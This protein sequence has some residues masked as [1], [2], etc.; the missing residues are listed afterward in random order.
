MQTQQAKS[1]AKRSDRVVIRIAT[2]T[3][4]PLIGDLLA[5]NGIVLPGESWE[6]V[7]PHWLVATDGD[8]V[9]GCL[10]VMPSRPAGWCEFLHTKPSASFKLRAIAIRKLIAAGMTSCHMAGCSYVMGMV[11][12]QNEKFVN[13]LER[14]GFSRVNRHAVMV[15]RLL[16]LH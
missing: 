5:E 14:V 10:Q 13:V 9:I 3:C 8:T 7:S 2:D 12:E 15:K 11:D 4:G 1:R 6:H 16:E